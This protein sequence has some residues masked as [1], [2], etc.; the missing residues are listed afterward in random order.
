MVLEC[1]ICKKKVKNS[2]GLAGHTNFAHK[3][4]N[5]IAGD[6]VLKQK[7]QAV[8]Y[9][10][11]NHDCDE[12]RD[13]FLKLGLILGFAK[14]VEELRE[15][16]MRLF[17]LMLLED[18]EFLRQS[19]EE[20]NPIRTVEDLRKIFWFWRE[21]GLVETFRDFEKK[22]RALSYLDQTVYQ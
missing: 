5:G 11:A 2:Q 21:A 20:E 6:V 12:H 22:A 1:P 8:E 18:P 7:R 19:M 16:Q 13:P 4:T 17:Q 3:T 10:F 15:K 9:P 14:T